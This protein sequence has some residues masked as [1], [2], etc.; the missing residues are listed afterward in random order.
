MNFKGKGNTLQV[1]WLGLGHLVSLGVGIGS[2]II[3]SRYFSKNEYGTY[4]Q[5]IYV[6][7]TLLIIF[8]AG[9]PKVYAYFLPKYSKEEG[10]FI[11]KK[12][13]NLLLYLG[14]LFSICLYLGADF[15]AYI[16][17]NPELSIGLRIFSPIPFLMLPTLGIEGIYSTYNNTFLIA[18]YNTITKLLML[19]CIVVPVIYFEGGYVFALYGWIVVSFISFVIALYLKNKPFKNT[20]Q[21][22]P[23]FNNKMIFSFSL[24]L[25][26]ASI[27]GIAITTSNH[28]FISRY[29]GMEEF[30]IFSN[31]FVQ[32]PFVFI[33]S[34]AIGTV[35]MPQISK[36][37]QIDK[38]KIGALYKSAIL[39]SAIILYPLISFFIIY[40]EEIV[41]FLFSVEYSEA[42]FYFVINLILNFL[43]IIMFAP[44]LLGLGESKFYSKIH[45]YCAIALWVLTY[46]SIVIFNS[47]YIVTV[48]YLLIQIALVFFSISKIL[49]IL[50]MKLNELVSIKKLSKIIIH[51]LLCSLSVYIVMKNFKLD[52]FILLSISFVS[53]FII[54]MLTDS[55]VKNSYLTKYKSIFNKLQ[56]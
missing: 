26:V 27:A 43:N 7:S 30:A 49:K 35:L 13:T 53:Y 21:I 16:L 52:L 6:Y 48:I 37:H 29:F 20:H 36:L 3:L 24:P 1:F 56:S 39:N 23:A 55:I 19:I 41:I 22:T 14:A 38:N 31:G 8:S 4:R 50:D 54:L 15:I 25:L 34:S 42:S 28:F 2:A 51:T 40:S 5:V 11:V 18:V 45:V 44:I 32:L 46:L 10:K 47:P 17:K 33:V 12:I 9:L